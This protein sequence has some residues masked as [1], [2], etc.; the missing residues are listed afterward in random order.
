MD[1]LF[2]KEQLAYQKAARDFA[3]EVIAP[4]AEKI[5]EDQSFPY[6]TWKKAGELGYLGL[7]IPEEY[8]GSGTDTITAA[9]VYEEVGKVCCSTAWILFP[10][11]MGCAVP[12]FKM[13][14]ED[15]IRKYVPKLASG[16]W[17]GCLGIT[18]P[19]TGSDVAGIETKALK[20][21]N[22]YVINGAKTFITNGTIADICFLIARTG[23]L[24]Q[25][26]KGLSCFIVEK[27]YSGYQVAKKLDKLGAR[28][29]PTAELVFIDMGVPVENRV[30]EEGKGFIKAMTALLYMRIGMCA[31][32]LGDC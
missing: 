1:F 4:V 32:S 15:Q 30:D 23:D 19:N 24:Q 6:E 22:N 10:H 8:G 3:K 21:G 17:M 7:C 28:G 25:G 27:N 18:E 12:I 2:T 26:S 13:G 14:N 16:E 20:K 11:T 9:L 31:T 5:D 29:S